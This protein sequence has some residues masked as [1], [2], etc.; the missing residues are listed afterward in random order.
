MC[1]R[2]RA[3]YGGWVPVVLIYSLTVVR[4][5]VVCDFCTIASTVSLVVWCGVVC[6]WCT[7]VSEYSGMVW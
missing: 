4:C 6:D 1:Y 2:C 5:G 3:H 7:I